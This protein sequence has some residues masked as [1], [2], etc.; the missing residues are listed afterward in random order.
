MVSLLVRPLVDGD[1]HKPWSPAEAGKGIGMV[2]APA[3]AT[4]VQSLARSKT[5]PPT[6]PTSPGEPLP[7]TDEVKQ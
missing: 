2:T 4:E 3:G 7:K 6:Q 1:L 5:G